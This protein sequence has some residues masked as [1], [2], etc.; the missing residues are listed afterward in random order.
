MSRN[1]ALATLVCALV[2]CTVSGRSSSASVHNV[3][4]FVPDG[5]RA[6]K[7]TAR[8]A[9]TMAAIRDHGVN[10]HN[11]HSLFPT[12]TTAN[13]SAFATGHLLGDTGDFSN[14]I[15]TGFPVMAAGGSVTPF[16]ENDTVLAEL[17]L[18]FDGNYL[19]EQSVLAAARDAKIQTAVIG[20]LGPAAIQDLTGDSPNA[21]LVVDDRTGQPDGRLIAG[22]ES[23]FSGAGVG[24]VAAARG[25]NGNQGDF[26]SPGTSVANITQQA[27]FR[28]VITRVVIPRFKD[29]GKPFFIVY[30]SR[31]PDG[32]QHN[33][34][35][36]LG[37][38]VPGIN[39]PTSLAAIRNA[40]DDLAA[41]RDTLRRQGLLAT[42]DIIIAAD[43]GFSTISKES[44]TSPA[45]K[46]T[47][48]DVTPGELP[49]GFLAIDLTESLK[50]S[51]P[52]LRLFDA[53]ANDAPVDLNAHQHPKQGSGLI[54][55]D[56]T[57]P[58][59][60]VAANGGSDLI[61]LPQ[62]DAESLLPQIVSALF[63]QDYTSGVFV[64]DG[65]GAPPG[66]LPMSLIGLTGS[67][68]TPVPALVVSFR[69]FSRGCER[70]ELCAVEIADTV[71]QQGQGMHGSF[72]RADTR[73]FM[74]AIGPDF[75]AGY[76]DPLAASNADVGRT[77][78]RLLDLHIPARGKLQGRILEEAL[79]GG[80]ERP[81]KSRT[82]VATGSSN[83]LKTML[84]QQVIGD[85]V[86]ND[87]A[88]FAN[89]T[90]GL[91]PAA[92]SR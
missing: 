23:A 72:S 52:E 83:D 32:T 88:G 13:A 42:T 41:I 91:R 33:Q 11:S 26:V 31:D 21:T 77:I 70:P 65:L 85:T 68:L 4:L 37:H 20:K 56:A 60:I 66:T 54:G 25:A 79:P 46:A 48:P 18:H 22:W 71:L 16:L 34:G 49:P 74:A 24:L 8:T 3:I 40:D 69:S 62:S 58:R 14:T 51:H 47:Y 59:I 35:D 63:A 57:A 86:Y 61:Y 67:A 12:F 87:V 55:A 92:S 44:R 39:G 45:A 64:Q 81:M 2:A 53:N 89:R 6:A 73:N 90:V 30:W 27:Y 28:D 84:R 15:Y 75:R 36:S 9:P 78:A 1:G 5:L 38:L 10:F 17:D 7:V 19:N 50:A 80:R 76:Q 29:S 43:H 82:T